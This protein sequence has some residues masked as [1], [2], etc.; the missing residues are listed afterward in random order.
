MPGPDQLHAPDATSG[1]PDRPLLDLGPAICADDI[2]S[3]ARERSGFEGFDQGCLVD[4]RATRCIDEDRA[5]LHQC[6][7][8]RIEQMMG[9]RG[10]GAVQAHDIR[11]FEEGFE[12]DP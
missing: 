10:Q 2:E 6:E 1:H 7:T 4:D 12:F 9:R 5:S 8:S 3:R 11:G